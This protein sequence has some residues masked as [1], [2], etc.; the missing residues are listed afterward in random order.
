MTDDASLKSGSL[1][2]LREDRQQQ[3]QQ[4]QPKREESLE[5]LPSASTEGSTPKEKKLSIDT[6][7]DDECYGVDSTTQVSPVKKNSVH[8]RKSSASSVITV[9][10]LA[11]E[12]YYSPVSS[13]RK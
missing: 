12:E 3:L 7:L 8:E 11:S 1:S 9:S 4:Q 2:K 13:P 6:K 10:T 5:M